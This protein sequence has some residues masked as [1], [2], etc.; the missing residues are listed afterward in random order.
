M[1]V[2]SAV[3]ES[4]RVPS[5][6]GLTVALP[7]F[8]EA[9]ILARL[10][11]MLTK[12][13]E[14]LDGGYELLFVDDG[15][16]DGTPGVLTQIAAR[17][18][19]VS[20][21]RLSRNFGVFAGVAAAVALAS[22]DSLII[23]DADLQDDPNVIPD[24]VRVQRE[25]AAE[26]VYVVR[27]GRKEPVPMRMCFALFYWLLA[28]SSDYAMP[29]DAGNFGLMGPRALA[30][31]RQLTERLRYFPGLRAFVGYKQVPYY[32]ARGERYDRTPRI[33]FWKLVRFAGLA[34]F[35]QSQIPI[36]LFY[37]LSGVSLTAACALAAYAVTGKIVGYAVVAWA[38]TMTSVA[39]FSS[40]I[41][42][43]QGVICEYL[44]RIYE[45]VRGRPVYIVEQ[46]CRAKV[47]CGRDL[48]DTSGRA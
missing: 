30:D 4:K 26:V 34:F 5:G 40:I 25:Q 39:F 9:E 45:E 24:L 35:S 47:V 42:L 2:G 18:P 8:N 11:A 29:R 46:I 44:S 1:G 27:T 19:H 37:M 32:L 10:H 15:S 21:V 23:M 3:A 20:V 16:T 33:G 13:C 43:G 22:G 31:M 38:S 7:V 36:K 12:A 48:D 28:R 17:D 6:V 14:S 41:I